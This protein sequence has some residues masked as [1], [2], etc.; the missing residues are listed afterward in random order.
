VDGV[1]GDRSVAELVIAAGR[2]D[3]EAWAGLVDRFQ[4]PKLARTGQGL[5][6]YLVQPFRCAEP[7][8][9]SPAERTSYPD[10]L[11][12][13]EQLLSDTDPANAPTIL[14]VPGIF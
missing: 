11:S 2:G 12:H 8:T 10:L 7:F 3:A 9:S 13:V 4:D 14:D 5:I 1:T 6:A